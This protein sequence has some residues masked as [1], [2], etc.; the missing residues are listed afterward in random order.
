[1]FGLSVSV[2]IEQSHRNVLTLWNFEIVVNYFIN[3]LFI[4]ALNELSDSQLAP[5][6]LFT[7]AVCLLPVVYLP[8]LSFFLSFTALKTLNPHQLQVVDLWPLTSL[9]GKSTQLSF[10]NQLCVSSCVSGQTGT[11]MLDKEMISMASGFGF[12]HSLSGIQALHVCVFQC[13]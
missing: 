5:H 9:G 6:Q 12:A 3:W 1:M 7:S 4:K 13:W 2:C 11:D 8:L 10:G